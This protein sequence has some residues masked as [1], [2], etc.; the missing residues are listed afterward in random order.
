[1]NYPRAVK[2]IKQ[3]EITTRCNLKCPYCPSPTMSRKKEDMSL[4][5]YLRALEWVKYYLDARTQ[6]E[7]SLTGIGESLLRYSG[8]IVRYALDSR[9]LALEVEAI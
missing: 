7:L 2:T 6:G 3:I 9:R 8:R 1:M 5:V 4:P